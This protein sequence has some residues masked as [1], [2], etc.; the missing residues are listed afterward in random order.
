MTLHHALDF[1]RGHEVNRPVDAL[2]E[3]RFA[4]IGRADDPED[5][6]LHDLERDVTERDLRSV[7]GGDV[8]E[9]DVGDRCRYHFFRDRKYTRSA[10]DS[11][12]TVSTMP[13]STTAVPY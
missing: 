11:R 1:A 4:R 13:K 6:A 5:L 3:C 7:A 10:I 9:G 8:L 12:F 2:Q